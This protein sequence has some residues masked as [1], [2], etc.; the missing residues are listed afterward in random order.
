MNA[1]SKDAFATAYGWS[2]TLLDG[3]PNPETKAQHRAR[4][5]KEY[6]KEITRSQE[7]IAARAVVIPAVAQD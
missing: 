3:S 1:R 7:T 5:I 4:R 6:I 2:A